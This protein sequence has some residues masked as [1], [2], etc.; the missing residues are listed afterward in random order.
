MKIPEWADTVNGSIT[1]CDKDG[2]IQYMNEA[3]QKSFS[4]D[5]GNSL[6]GKSLFPCHNQNSAQMI[7]TMVGEGNTN[8]YTIT[9]KGV[10]KLIYQTPYFEDGKVAGL[11]EFSFV[12]PEEMPHHNRD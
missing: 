6:V 9:K 1:V 7:R 2:I 12:I 5:G 8:A 11:V 3:S 4:A 10:R